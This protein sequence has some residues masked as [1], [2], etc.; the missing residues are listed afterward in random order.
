MPAQTPMDLVPT[1]TRLQLGP[2]KCIL[3]RCLYVAE[4]TLP[5]IAG[6]AVGLS[7]NWMGPAARQFPCHRGYGRKHAVLDKLATKAPGSPWHEVAPRGWRNP[8][9]FIA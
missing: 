7:P 1:N 5:G 3:P 4:N 9:L 6:G 8:I 2:H